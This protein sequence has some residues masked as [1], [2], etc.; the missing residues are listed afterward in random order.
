MKNI[1]SEK[2]KSLLEIK[3]NFNKL[4]TNSNDKGKET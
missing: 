3:L 1:T 2:R 4:K